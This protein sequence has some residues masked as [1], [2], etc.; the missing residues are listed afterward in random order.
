MNNLFLHFWENLGD[1]KHPCD[2]SMRQGEV[3]PLLI[4]FRTLTVL[5]VLSGRSGK[6][7]QKM[8]ENLFSKK[9]NSCLLITMGD[10]QINS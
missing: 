3:F 9:V 6:N 10:F 8:G 5:Y 2:A 1:F 4:D 7:F